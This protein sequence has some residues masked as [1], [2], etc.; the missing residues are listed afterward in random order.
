MKNR[1]IKLYQFV[2]C[3]FCI[4]VRRFLDENNIEYEKVNVARDRKDKMRKFLFEKSGV[5]TVPVIEIDGKYI[6]ESDDI[7]EYAENL[8]NKK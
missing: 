7:I 3:P 1:K 4:K 5:K 2:L 6:G 8:D